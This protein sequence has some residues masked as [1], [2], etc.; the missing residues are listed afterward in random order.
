MSK[1]Y[2]FVIHLDKVY[3]PNPFSWKHIENRDEWKQKVRELVSSDRWII[4]GHY[5]S[6]LNIRVPRANTIIFFNFN[7][8]LCLYR[9]CKR[10]MNK[11]QPFDKAEGN[12]NRLSWNLIKKIIIFSQKKVWGHLEPHKDTKKIYVVH[13]SKETE[14]LLLEL[15]EN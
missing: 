11:T 13:N 5:N 7:K 2:F 12:F 8:I 3:Y 4:D 9:V 1:Y 10:A 15:I 6:T 14:K